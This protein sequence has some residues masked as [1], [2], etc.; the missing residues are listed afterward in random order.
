MSERVAATA[1]VLA[2]GRA[3]R[4]GSDKLTADVHG[5]PLL[6]RAIGAVTEVCAEVLV[7]GPPSGLS[8]ELPAQDGLTALLDQAPFEGPL[9][10]LVHAAA[11][12][13][14]QRLI[15]VG[16]DMPNLQMPLLRR[17][18]V[19]PEGRYGAC[20]VADG[21]L[22]PLPAGLARPAIVERGQALLDAGERSLRALVAALDVERIG[23]PEWRAVDPEAL[24]LR[25]I[26]R[27]EDLA[28][29]PAGQ[30]VAT[31]SPAASTPQASSAAIDSARTAP[32]Q[33]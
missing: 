4:F 7:V 2:G 11:A 12:A 22:R 29:E 18:L 1:I 3:R 20:L 17:L 19:W 24:S 10:A 8:I 15:V 27:P 33:R 25:D 14:H 30:S 32:N 26:D 5:E 16:G 23:E 9:A 31:V 28:D 13:E 6:M 21:E